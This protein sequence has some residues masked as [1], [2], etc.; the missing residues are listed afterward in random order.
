MSVKALRRDSE[1]T[2][3]CAYLGLVNVRHLIE[4]LL[5]TKECVDFE[6]KMSPNMFSTI[7]RGGN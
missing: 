7:V 2:F 4:Q 5:K 1:A 3:V 6:S